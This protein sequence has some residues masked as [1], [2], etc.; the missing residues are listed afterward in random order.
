MQEIITNFS[1]KTNRTN[2]FSIAST[3]IHKVHSSTDAHLFKLS[4]KFTLELY[5]SYMFRSTTIIRE[6]AIE[7]D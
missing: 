4:L 1:E 5:G 6:S 3:A 7:P 2:K